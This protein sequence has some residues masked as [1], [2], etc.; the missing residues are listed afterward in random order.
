MTGLVI[1]ILLGAL[2]LAGLWA[3]RSRGPL[4]TIAAAAL[5]FGGAG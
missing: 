4:L 5:M 3:L 1:L 2:S